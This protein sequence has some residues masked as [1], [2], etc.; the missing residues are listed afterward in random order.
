MVALDCS[1][2]ILRDKP[3]V[4]AKIE[5]HLCIIRVTLGCL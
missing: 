4:V 3:V 2:Q 1:A 5:E